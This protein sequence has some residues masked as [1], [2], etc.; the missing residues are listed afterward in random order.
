M[1]NILFLQFDFEINTHG[2]EDKN[3]ILRGSKTSSELISKILKE[4]SEDINPVFE[5]YH[6]IY[7]M[8]DSLLQ[9]GYDIKNYNFVFFGFISRDK[10]IQK[11][12]ENYLLKNKV[13]YIKYGGSNNKLNDLTLIKELGLDYIPTVITSS[14]NK[15]ILS[16][17]END[18]SFPV[19][20]KNPYLQKGMGVSLCS[21]KKELL[22]R[23]RNNFSPLLVQKFIENDGDYRIIIFKNKFL[24]SSKRQKT[25]D[26]EFRNNIALGGKVVDELPPSDII[27]M[28]EFISTK[29]NY[30]DVLGFDIIQD[31]NT[32]KYFIMEINTGPHFFSFSV[33]SNIDVVNIFCNYI[34]NNSKNNSVSYKPSKTDINYNLCKKPIERKERKEKVESTLEVNINI[35]TPKKSITLPKIKRSIIDFLPFGKK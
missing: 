10:D 19:V 2:I 17:I 27:K 35:E 25:K 28:C 4:K 16:V 7:M 13:P 21:S 8:G 34:L 30:S 23:F 12:I 6:N 24:L 33:S 31:K 26:D 15:D 9:N 18:F 29:I 14:I 32:G 5:T 20:V 3:N 11:I 22:S 1:T